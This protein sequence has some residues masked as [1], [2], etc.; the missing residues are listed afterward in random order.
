MPIAFETGGLQQLDPS[1]WGNPVTGDLVTLAYVDA[2]PDLP[3]PLEDID[4]L[5]RGLTELQA[6]FGCLIEAHALTVAGQPA[7]LRLEKFP[8]PD[9][10]GLG[11]TAGI[12]LPKATCS[13][14]LKI[15]CRETGRSGVR[16]AAIVPK[17]GFQNMFRAHPYA[18][19]VRGK[20]PYNV[21]DD[22]QWDP[23]FPDHP[24]TRARRWIS[25]I[26]RTAGVD[27][28]FAAL[29][30]FTGPAQPPEPAGDPSETA[31]APSV[32][33]STATPDAHPTPAEPGPS[34]AA[35]TEPTPSG[36]PAPSPTADGRP[37]PGGEIGLLSS[38]GEAGPMSPG[39]GSTQSGAAGSGSMSPGVG[40][41]TSGAVESGLM[42]SGGGPAS[43]AAQGG[44]VPS[45]A[46]PESS[47]AEAGRTSFTSGPEEPA[48]GSNR[49]APGGIPRLPAAAAQYA[50]TPIGAAT[51]RG[52]RRSALLAQA[53]A[54]S[55]AQQPA[56]DA[57]SARGRL[58]NS[59]SPMDS[60]ETKPIP[61]AEALG[62]KPRGSRG[63]AEPTGARGGSGADAPWLPPDAAET[64]AIPAGSAGESGP[65][66]PAESPFSVRDS[67]PRLPPEAPETTAISAVTGSR[68]GS[69]FSSEPSEP[70]ATPTDPAS[71]DARRL[72]ADAPESAP[73]EPG[74]VD[75]TDN[76]AATTA[77]PAATGGAAGEASDPGATTAFPARAVSEDASGSSDA[78][79]TAF[80]GGTGSDEADRASAAR[81]TAI[82]TGPIRGLGGRLSSGSRRAAD[83]PDGSS[84]RLPASAERRTG[85]DDPHSAAIPRV[86][87]DAEET[88]AIPSGRRRAED[89]PQSDGSAPVDSEASAGAETRPIPKR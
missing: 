2:V 42:S 87:P 30:P 19:E 32:G 69:R 77:I 46:G 53:S 59:Q 43:F 7:L 10:P 18:P 29:P 31:P 40:P 6:E 71:P 66:F 51:R 16:E 74:H 9:R 21:A 84:P 56:E 52:D 22:A 61:T 20:L 41:T 48:P 86:R 55:N 33:I 28:R 64:T 25:H 26:S 27:P 76:P 89:R 37:S 80:P 38:G 45:D 75:D 24:L 36:G 12:V 88:T 68:I 13:A 39:G 15:M 14:I 70:P 79:T 73:R 11:F 3:A 34:P 78:E 72:S 83:T 50:G 8:L 82:P 4:A 63:A 57:P 49:P 60:T 62:S 65:R 81:T 35:E 1:T 47:S 58:G 5:R 67:D 44:P 17:V 54:A 85:P 23:Q